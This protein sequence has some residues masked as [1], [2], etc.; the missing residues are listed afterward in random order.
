MLSEEFKSG[1][2]VKGTRSRPRPGRKSQPED[3]EF[4]YHKLKTELARTPQM[5]STGEAG[6]YIP[7][8]APQGCTLSEGCSSNNRDDYGFRRRRCKNSLDPYCL[9]ITGPFLS[10]SNQNRIKP[11]YWL[12][13]LEALSCIDM[14]LLKR[15][16]WCDGYD[17]VALLTSKIRSCLD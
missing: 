8:H 14:C 17:A 13:S 4:D 16:E 11:S 15:A 12:T 7:V 5:R 9:S 6:G 1:R 2:F 10:S 3:F